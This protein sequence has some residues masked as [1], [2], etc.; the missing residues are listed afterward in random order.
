[1][2]IMKP[3]LAC[4]FHPSPCCLLHLL[5]AP[6]FR[7]VR[8]RLDLQTAAATTAIVESSGLV[9]LAAFHLVGVGFSFL[10]KR[11]KEGRELGMKERG[12]EGKSF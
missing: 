1:M 9:V 12:G 10:G 6:H 5:C 8:P 7:L 3:T 11:G 2:S 4:H